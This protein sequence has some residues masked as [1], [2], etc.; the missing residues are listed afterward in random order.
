MLQISIR[1]YFRL[2]GKDHYTVFDLPISV[3]NS[4]PAD[5]SRPS[6]D[7]INNPLLP[8]DEIISDSSIGTLFAPGDSTT[9]ST[10]DNSKSNGKG[11]DSGSGKGSGS[12]NGSGSGGGSSDSGLGSPKTQATPEDGL[13]SGAPLI[14]WR[15]SAMMASGLWAVA[16]LFL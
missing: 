2:N 14:S 4:I 16:F 6:C 11:N 15:T 1:Q 5:P 10:D 12:G 9:V 8:P 3:T 7:S 13:G